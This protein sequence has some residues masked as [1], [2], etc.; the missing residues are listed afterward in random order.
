LF[1]QDEGIENDYSSAEL[2]QDE[3]SEGVDGEKTIFFIFTSSVGFILF[4]YTSCVTIL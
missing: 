1:E 2:S 3:E 4:L